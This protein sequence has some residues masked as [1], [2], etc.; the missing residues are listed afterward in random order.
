MKRFFKSSLAFLLLLSACAPRFEEEQEV[1]QESN[2]QTERAIIPKYII[3]DDYY[4]TILPFKPGKARGLVVGT[5]DNRLDIDE[6]ELGLMRVAREE[7]STDDYYFQE[8]Q[9]LTSDIVLD[10]LKREKPDNVGLNPPLGD[11][12]SL[13]ERHAKSPEYLSHVLEH[14]YLKKNKEGKVE[15]AGVV[16]GLSLNSI[17]YFTQ[18]DGFPRSVEIPTEEVLQKGKEI[19]GEVLS[20]IRKIE[21]L[22]TV[23]I[24]LALYKE[25]A[26]GDIVPGN[27]IAKTIVDEK[28]TTISEWE[29]IDEEY[30]FFPSEEASEN[31]Y[32]DST[33]FL[34][35]KGDVEEYFPNFIGVIGRGF[36]SRGQLQE[37]II[38]I[39]IQFYGKAELIGFT[40]YV[41]GLV[42]DHFPLYISVKVYVNSIDGSESIIV[43]ETNDDE[44][45][46][47]IYR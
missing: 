43:R 10:W 20:R 37:L 30:H 39:P 3:S 36:Y 11:E 15:L 21:G 31:Y 27:F 42:M 38:E 8:G 2:N 26:Q 19:S 24:I 4:R 28:Q 40:E 35:F 33:K 17:H 22:E 34:N 44:P 1:I 29:T 6:L 46:I 12:G 45:F 25:A 32:D 23:P 18:E 47:H 7:F 9:Y 16:I 5:V 13:E 14:N 41:A